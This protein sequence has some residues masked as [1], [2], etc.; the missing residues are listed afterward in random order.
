MSNEEFKFTSTKDIMF[1]ASFACMS[2][3]VSH[4]GLIDVLSSSCLAGGLS[5]TT[6]QRKSFKWISKVYLL[7]I[8]DVFESQ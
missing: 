7:K 1:L 8:A 5:S 6:K 4:K 2:L 3:S